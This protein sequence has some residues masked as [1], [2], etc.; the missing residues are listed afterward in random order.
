MEGNRNEL[1]L[2]RSSSRQLPGAEDQKQEVNFVLRG[3]A[4]LQKA[5]LGPGRNSW[6]KFGQRSLEDG[7][8]GASNRCMGDLMRGH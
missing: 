1:S 2:V 8:E 6:W 4:P 3:F 7:S 5:A